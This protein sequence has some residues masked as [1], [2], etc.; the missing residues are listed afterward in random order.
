MRC[1]KN[2]VDLT[3]VERERLADAFNDV[4]SRGV[5]SSMA[6][7]HEDHFNHG[8]HR[9]P[10]FLPWHRHFLLR[11][12]WELRQFDDRV[13]L[14]YWD[15]TRADSRDLDVEPWK[16]FFG[17]RPNTGGRFDHWNYTRRSHPNGNV[18]PSLNSVLAELGAGS[19][20]AFRALECGS[21]VPGHTWTG[22]TMAGGRSPEDPLF[23]LHHGNI[24][25]LWAIWQL[26]HPAPAFDQYSTATGGGCDQN[27]GADVDLNTPMHGGATPASM[28]NHVA[29]GYVYHPDDLLL[30]AAQAA[31]NAGFISGDPLTVTLETPQ[32]VFNDVPEGD[33][34]HRA[35]LFRIV[36]CGTL[37]FQAVINAGPFVLA[38]PSPYSFPGSD[39]PT[40]QFRVWVQYTG[41]APGTLDQGSMGIVAH[42]A[43]G[44]EVWRD[45]DIP[46]VA[47]SVRRPR[48]SVTMVLDESGSMLADAGNNRMRLEVL[49]F[50]ATT[51]VDQLFDDNGVAMVAF[52]DAA[53][54]I[55]D[56]EVAG[57]LMSG[58]RIDLRDKIGDHGPPNQQPHTCIGAG[59]EQAANLIAASPISGDFEVNATIV[60]TDG[61]EDRDPRIADVQHLINDRVYA[62]GVANAANVANDKLRAIADNSG[63]FMLVTGALAQD[64][65]FLLDKFFI[66]IL[67]GVLNRDIVYDPEGSVGFGEVARI[68][69]SITRSDIAFDAVALTRAPQFL[70]IALQAPDGTVIGV[71]QL[72]PG[73][74]RPGATSRTLRVTLPL[75]IDGKEHWGGEWQLLMALMGRGDAAKLTHMVGAISAPGQAPRLP[76][77]ALFHARS[78]LNMR[79]T[80]SQSGVAP[81]STLYVRATLTEYGRPLATHPAVSGTVTLPD[82]STMMV[83]LHETAPG[84]FE[85]SLAATQNGA[86][87]VHLVAGGLS[88]RGQRFTREHLLSA[89]IGRAAQPGDPRPGDGGPG[90]GRPGGGDG[91]K[92]LLCC[93]LGEQVLTDR[94]ARIAERLGI[95]IDRL[96]RCLKL[97]CAGEQKPPIIR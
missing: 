52:S 49:Q 79:A 34:T 8:I 15:W 14:P 37:M 11:L 32:V 58:V 72:P 59:I 81:G 93:L 43:F 48:A 84:V 46:I 1:R 44:D 78:N 2:F 68:P 91:V 40:D 4:F 95:D 47:N 86:Y 35:A 54:T 60:F 25:R 87:L 20:Q 83:A 75:L 13:S 5:I 12:E 45:D 7:E 80:L 92:D 53:Q 56:L 28:L 63:G 6:D 64:D 50:A 76:Y 3:P 94:F 89:L 27:T 57:D 10:A 74:Y 17:G 18:L 66:Q 19:F 24:D 67:A 42:N 85:T 31:G 97:H 33:T 77:H 39:F 73:S 36:G 30:A 65:E 88:S 71:S 96:R 16:S 51:F 82:Q 55:R 29:L 61:I 90:G 21:H 69:F 38:D 9:G 62:V 70:A 22:E 26:N 41:Q 23:Y